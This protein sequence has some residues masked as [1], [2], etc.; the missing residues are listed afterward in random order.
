MEWIKRNLLFKSSKVKFRNE[1]ESVKET[2]SPEDGFIDIV[3]ADQ[4]QVQVQVKSE[5]GDNV[6]EIGDNV[7]DKSVPLHDIEAES[8]SETASESATSTNPTTQDAPDIPTPT[9]N[10]A[11]HQN[12]PNSRKKPIKPVIY[13]QT[14][15]PAIKKSPAHHQSAQQLR[16]CA[17][18]QPK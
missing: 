9:N 10:A 12:Q 7:A 14:P 6:A 18:H 16:S 5:I 8:S 2:S 1:N 17:I 13:Q 15:P 3:E 4:Q 11:S